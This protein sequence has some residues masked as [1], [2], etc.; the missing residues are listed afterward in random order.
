MA[1]AVQYNLIASKEFTLKQTKTTLSDITAEIADKRAF[2]TVK[3]R[4]LVELDN[5]VDALGA[6]LGKTRDELKKTRKSLGGVIGGFSAFAGIP[7]VIIAV[8]LIVRKRR[9]M[10]ERAANKPVV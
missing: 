9:D 5:E 2:L 10:K 1:C 4:D 6:Q 8:I 3:Q 7:L